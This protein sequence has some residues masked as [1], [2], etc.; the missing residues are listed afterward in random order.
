[1]NPDSM[2][3]TGCRNWKMETDVCM[4]LSILAPRTRCHNCELYEPCGIGLG[5]VVEKVIGVA[6]LGT[7][8]RIARRAARGDCGCA[9]RRAALN[10][11]GKTLVDRVTG[12]EDARH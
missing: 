1:M 12:G 9:K 10:R 3:H 7:A 4:A 11:A 2:K 8:K 6:T 5:D